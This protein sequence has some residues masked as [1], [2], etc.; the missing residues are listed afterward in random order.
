MIDI[1]S[2]KKIIAQSGYIKSSHYPN[3]YPATHQ[4]NLTIKAHS[5]Q[6]IRLYAIDLDLGSVAG[7]GGN[8]QYLI[9]FSY[10][11]ACF[12]HYIQLTHVNAFPYF[13]CF[14][15]FS[16]INFQ[17]KVD[18]ANLRFMIVSSSQFILFVAFNS[19]QNQLCA[20]CYLVTSHCIQ[21]INIYARIL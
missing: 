2:Q 5:S 10:L 11:N 1:C 16:V 12:N 14:K 15:S 19:L 18:S 6:Q 21:L 7:N 8:G 3:N 9:P 4:C 20:T 13:N 17:C